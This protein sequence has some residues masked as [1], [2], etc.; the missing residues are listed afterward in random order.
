MLILRQIENIVKFFPVK[1]TSLSAIVVLFFTMNNIAE[2]QILQ[3][4]EFTFVALPR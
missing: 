4:A 3:V 2:L 1:G